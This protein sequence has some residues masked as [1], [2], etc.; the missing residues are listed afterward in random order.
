MNDLSTEIYNVLAAIRDNDYGPGRLPGEMREII[1]FLAANGYI[2][3]SHTTITFRGKPIEFEKYFFTPK[4][5]NAVS[6]YEQNAKQ[7]AEDEERHDREKQEQHEIHLKDKRRSNTQWA[8]GMIVA[9]I[10]AFFAGSFSQVGTSFVN[11]IAIHFVVEEQSFSETLEPIE[12]EIESSGVASISFY[13][14][15]EVTQ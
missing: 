6:L 15:G 4:G 14:R 10:L 5:L 1:R 2:D 7:R 13:R 11:W 12:K 9:I 8:I 3:A